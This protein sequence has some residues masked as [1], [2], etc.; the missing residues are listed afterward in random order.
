M[1]DVVWQLVERRALQLVVAAS[2]GA[3]QMTHALDLRDS[4][5]G[6]DLR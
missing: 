5:H 4:H 1:P 6:R 3:Q 2:A